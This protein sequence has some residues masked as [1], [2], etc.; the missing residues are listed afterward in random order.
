M[1]DEESAR[2]G[3]GLDEKGGSQRLKAID[4]ETQIPEASTELGYL[5]QSSGALGTWDEFRFQLHKRKLDSQI[6]LKGTE[7]IVYL[8][9]GLQGLH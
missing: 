5:L 9:G 7:S 4:I 3:R 8:I 1:L 2:A 6:L